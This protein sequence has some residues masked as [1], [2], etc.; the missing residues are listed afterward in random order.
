MSRRSKLRAARGPDLTLGQHL[1]ELRSRLSR[2]ALALLLGACVG[3][4]LTDAIWSVLR[5]PIDAVAQQGLV[6]ASINYSTISSAF[7]LRMQTAITF[8]VIVSSPIWLFQLL[9]FLVPGLTRPERK[10][11]LG[12]V[13]ASAPLFAT[14]CV[15]GWMLIPRMVELMTSFAPAG[16]SAFIDARSYFDFALKLLLATGVAF[17]LPVLLVAL[18]MMGV[19]TGRGLL[20]GWRV[21]TV[22]VTAFA[23]LATP[24]ADVLSMALLA[25]PLL[26]LYFAATFV[27][28]AND[29]RRE[30]RL[31]LESPQV[32]LE[33]I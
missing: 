31:I 25:A 4:F 33:E 9:A 28:M 13:A 32:V 14:G 1:R 27:A 16:T 10:Y 30:R 23:A 2:A 7:D 3:W 15:V 29:R 21:G 6:N 12:F 8:G 24:A 20:R 11:V 18:N 22:A 5:A 26:A 17:I 19:V